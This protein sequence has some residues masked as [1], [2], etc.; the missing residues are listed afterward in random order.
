MAKKKASKKG[1][2]MTVLLGLQGMKDESKRGVGKSASGA[3]R[4]AMLRLSSEKR[5]A[6]T[7]ATVLAK[8]KMVTSSR[9]VADLRQTSGGPY[10]CFSG[11]SGK[12]SVT[13]CKT[14]DCKSA[15]SRAVGRLTGVGDIRK[16]F[17]Q[18]ARFAKRSGSFVSIEA[19]RAAAA[20]RASAP[21]KR[22]GS[23]GKT[24]KT[25]VCLPASQLSM[26]QLAASVPVAKAKR[27]KR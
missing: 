12:K 23:K 18:M 14:A 10:P 26:E 25:V 1:G 16:A 22:S 8:R 2:T 19:A 4:S 9:I 3:L 27:G 21:A 6:L 13:V 17:G 7:G 11:Q 5:A 24:A 20:A 15:V